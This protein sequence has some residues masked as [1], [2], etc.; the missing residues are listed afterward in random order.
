[1][2]KRLLVMSMAAL[3]VMNLAACSGLLPFGS[4]ENA[5]EE[6]NVVENVEVQ[7]EEPE[8]EKPVIEVPD[9]TE[10]EDSVDETDV[11]ENYIGYDIKQVLSVVSEERAWVEYW[12][13]DTNKIALID[14]EGNELF[15]VKGEQPSFGLLSDG[16]GFCDFSDMQNGAAYVRDNNSNTIYIVDKDGNVLNSFKNT[17]DTNY[18]MIGTDGGMFIIYEFTSSFSSNTHIFHIVDSSGAII[19]SRDL[20]DADSSYSTKAELDVY[21]DLVDDYTFLIRFKSGSGYTDA[22]FL[23]QMDVPNVVYANNSDLAN[24]LDGTEGY[25]VDNCWRSA[26]ILPMDNYADDAAF[27]GAL[28]TMGDNG[29]R[30]STEDDRICTGVDYGYVFFE[31]YE[32][33]VSPFYDIKAQDW[34]TILTFPE[35]VTIDDIMCY[36]GYCFYQMTGNDGKHYVTT[37]D[38]KGNMLYEPI[39]S[40]FSDYAL[41]NLD[42]STV[43]SSNLDKFLLGTG[44]TVTLNKLP[45]DFKLLV[46]HRFKD[47]AI[48]LTSAISDGYV[49]PYNPSSQLNPNGLPYYFQSLDGSVVV[50]TVKEKP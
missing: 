48:Y 44:E 9:N 35:G 17:A 31:A 7:H 20:S 12:N 36:G 19:Y 16:S 23:A 14:I 4:N 45:N 37:A 11:S 21:A 49:V 15:S 42:G 1:M 22:M 8:H 6:A 5:Q 3:M 43:F 24:T 13:G 27:A 26:I 28:E 10:A 18:S 40:P 34:V 38:T 46:N 41:L 2:K 50:S 39:V 25:F 33:N 29:T 32:Y 47:N 30:I